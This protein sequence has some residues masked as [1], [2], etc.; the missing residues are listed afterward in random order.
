[1]KGSKLRLV[2]LIISFF[3]FMSKSNAQ[4]AGNDNTITICTKENYNQGIGN[5]NGVVNLFTLLG[6][7]AVNGGSWTNLNS[8]GG[9]NTSTGI[10]NTWQINQSGIYSYQY[11][12]NGIS[13]CTDNTSIITLT[14]GGFPGVDNPSAVAC[15][16]NAS[17]PLFSFLGS[18]PNPHFNGT[19]SGGPAGS[20]NGNFFNAQL[21]GIG[22]YTL[23]YTVPAIGSCP[24]RSANVSLTVHPLP[25]SGIPSNLTFCET[26]DFSGFTNINLFNQLSGEDSGGFWSDNFPTGEISGI[27]DSFINI[28]NIATNFGPGTYTFTYNV[29]PTHPICTPA[30]SNVAI[31]IEPIIDINGANL[32]ITPTPICYENLST[33]IL[34]ATITQGVNPIPDGTYNI[35]YTLSG[36]NSGT[37]TVSITFIGGIGTFIINSAF[38]NSIGITTV[39]ITNIINPSSVTN[40][41]RP[42]T[43]LSNTF[44]IAESPNVNDT[45]I[46]VTNFCL[47]E[48]GQVVI[49]DINNSNIELS[50]DRYII[51]YI[52][53]DPNGLQ[54]TETIVIIV[55][56]GDGVF[57][58]LNSLITIPGNY[59]VTIINVENE[60]SGCSTDTNITSPF[61][62][63]P[64]P[65]ADNII[66]SIDDVCLGDTVVVTLSSAN[67]LSD[68]L[69]DLDYS[70]FG[71]INVSNQIVNNVNFTNGSATFT[72]PNT[73]LTSGAST[74]VLNVLTSVSNTC[75][76]SSFNDAS[77][78]FII[79]PLPDTTGATITAIDICISEIETIFIGNANILNDGEYTILYDL[80]GSNNSTDNSVIVTFTNGNGDFTIPSSLLENG[81][82]TTIT[83]QNISY[84]VTN[85][86][87]TDLSANPINFIITDPGVPS[88]A[89]DGNLF[90][91]QDL[92]NP[93]IANLT[94]NITSTGTITWYDAPLNG[95]IYTSTDPITNGT[96]YYASLTDAQGCEGSSRLEV[97]VDLTFCP[98]LFIPDGFSPNNDGLN[99]TFYI[100]D[101]DVIYPNHVLEIYN[102]YGN[103][104]YKGDIN[105]PDFDGKSNQSTV[106]GSDILPT[107]VY[108]YIL[109][110][111]D[112]TNKKPTQGRLYLSR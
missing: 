26:D 10:L 97:I 81:G 52:I 69:Y 41:T 66:V 35:T 73:I 30:S 5:P 63:F 109:H 107:G 64:I 94:S 39:N 92:P 1:M 3:V 86:G 21:A 22:T 20:V 90:C 29:N 15:D 83:I 57:S 19:W 27:G 43:N 58:I 103:L 111:N 67:N 77:D 9:L 38:V 110:Y 68:G 99:D 28:Q 54:T 48:T 34:T 62:V 96:T 93:T 13:G 106:L 49:S 23:T 102:R 17:V 14:L 85:C 91:L 18:S 12:I 46:S 72:L 100:K 76:T 40:C 51:T 89:V 50:D 65:E 104:I 78:N 98:N 56:N 80:T 16:N 70:I 60:N 105:T 84:N 108:F 4:C 53:T 47:G 45:Q 8:S 7:G 61:V 2:M 44:E 11:T 55:T 24:S 101:V 37:E 88:L 25:E 32:N 6:V 59:T 74:F 33:T 42:I 95:N 31:I 112:S 87:T 82:T 36:V 71:A 75:G 79:N